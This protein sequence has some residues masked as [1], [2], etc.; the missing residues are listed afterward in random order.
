MGVCFGGMAL[1]SDNSGTLDSEIL[2]L[3]DLD[4]FSLF[5]TVSPTV[6]VRQGY[7]PLSFNKSI[8][9]LFCFP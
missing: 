6:M 3:R 2:L 8:L 5:S 4:E 9:P 1:D 7:P